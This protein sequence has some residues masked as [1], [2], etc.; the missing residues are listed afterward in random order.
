LNSKN[1]V[2]LF[3][4]YK[5]PLLQNKPTPFGAKVHFK[6][7]NRFLSSTLTAPLPAKAIIL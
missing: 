3:Y 4:C 5:K 1:H 7:Q 6:L 2:P